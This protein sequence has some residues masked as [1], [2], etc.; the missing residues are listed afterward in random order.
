MNFIKRFKIIKLLLIKN[1]RIRLHNKKSFVLLFL[2]PIIF[3]TVVFSIDRRRTTYRG[4]ERQHIS[5]KSVDQTKLKAILTSP[6]SVFQSYYKHIID[7]QKTKCIVYTPINNYTKNLMQKFEDLLKKKLSLEYLCIIPAKNESQF[8]SLLKETIFLYNDEVNYGIKFK[9]DDNNEVPKHLK[10]EISVSNIALYNSDLYRDLNKREETFDSTNFYIQQGF[11]Q[12][13]AVIDLAHIS[14]ASNNLDLNKLDIFMQK[15]PIPERSQI[16]SSIIRLDDSYFLVTLIMLFNL[17]VMLPVIVKRIVE[18]KATR[19]SDYLVILG[20]GKTEHWITILIDSLSILGFQSLIISII[21]K[22]PVYKHVNEDGHT[23]YSSS[24]LNR[25][26]FSLFIA[27]IFIFLIQSIL[28]ACL[29]SVFFK[30]P[31]TAVVTT[32]LTWILLFFFLE[33]GDSNHDLWGTES[34]SCLLPNCALFWFI[35]IAKGLYE[36]ARSG[37]SWSHISDAGYLTDNM[38]LGHVLLIMLLSYPL[39]GLLI[40]YL[41]SVIEFES[42]IAKP[43]YFPLQDLYHYF[44]KVPKNAYQS[45][46]DTEDHSIIIKNLRKKYKSKLGLKNEYVLKNI[47]LEIEDKSITVILGPNGSGKTTLI[48][49]IIGNNL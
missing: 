12:I 45:I 21:L 22:T 7:R 25:F 37:A 38:T 35:Y 42:S 8:Y 2:I 47:D 46:F 30:S 29:I 1:W 39:Y 19:I 31:N 11:C 33:K 17:L 10:Y 18:E 28:F 16:K 14:I 44:K 6:K 26:D 9:I 20:I 32:I 27:F 24:L 3:T 40:W 48:N 43:F 49:I 36:N 23:F 4:F 34:L 41:S 15:M 5:K 13:Q